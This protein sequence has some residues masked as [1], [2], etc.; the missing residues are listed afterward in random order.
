MCNRCKQTHA[1]QPATVVAKFTDLQ[2][3]MQKLLQVPS[4]LG[5]SAQFD[6]T[7]KVQ[8]PIKTKLKKLWELPKTYHCPVIG[9][10]LDV[11]E[12]CKLA[13]QARLDI[14]GL[15]DY[16]LHSYFV[17]C[18]DTPQT[19]GKLINKYLMRKYAS[20]LKRF[21]QT[22]TLDE[23]EALWEH[24]WQRGDIAAA[25]WSILIHPNT[26]MALQQRVYGEVHM[27]SHQVGA[28]QRTDLRKM[29]ELTDTC[30]DLQQ[31]LKSTRCTLNQREQT[32]Q[33]LEKQLKQAQ[34]AQPTQ[35]HDSLSDPIAAL[36][37][38]LQ[39]ME[40]QQDKVLAQLNAYEQ[41]YAALQENLQA[42]QAELEAEQN[43]K[44]QLEIELQEL[45]LCQQ[46]EAEA[47]AA[48][49]EYALDL[50]G[51]CILYVGGR[52]KLKPHLRSIVEQRGGR[53]IHHDGGLH[54]KVQHLEQ[55]LCQADAVFCPL[56]CISHNACNKVK[57]FCKKHE[58]PMVF[59]QRESLAA[60][61][62]RLQENPVRDYTPTMQ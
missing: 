23:L 11:D 49:N 13:R 56:N 24:A 38:Q 22:K 7:A 8:L 28:L 57:Q 33:Q 20:T 54:N 32:I 55:L 2:T 14:E 58:K 36:T 62:K 37:Q 43:E 15:T 29:H 31:E 4:N 44:Q 16:E 41:R 60:F 46:G 25:F 59:L 30:N 3:S 51:Q 1:T 34:Y 40:K 50:N 27:L 26:T 47:D 10:C 19:L 21:N 5:Y 9:T 45:L 52:N 17:G 39:Q 12:L 6:K 53:F 61:S 35:Q 18:A 48:D 42:V